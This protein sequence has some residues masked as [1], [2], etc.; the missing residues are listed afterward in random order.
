LPR[1]HRAALAVVT[2]AAGLACALHISSMSGHPLFGYP[3]VDAR[4][5]FEWASAVS[6]G[7][8][9]AFAPYFRAPLYPWILG[10]LFAL[11]GPS[12][13]AGAVLSALMVTASAALFYKIAAKWTSPGPALTVSLVWA[14]WAPQFFLSATLLM[15]P[16]YLLLLLGSFLAVDSG[17]TGAGMLLLGLS[18]ITRPGSVILLPAVFLRCGLVPG[19]RRL[20]L[21][22][23]PIAGVWAVNAIS[24]D[25]GT[26]ISSQGGVNFCLGNG[27]DADGVTAFAPVWVMQDPGAP[28]ED[29]VHA[30]SL[31]LAP[32]GLR[33]SAVSSWWTRRTLAEISA[34]F[35]RWLGLLGRKV[36]YFLS[37]VEVPGNYEMYYCRRYSFLL[38]S[39]LLPPPICV[40]AAIILLMLPGALAG[41]RPTRREAFLGIW[42]LLL[43]AGVVAFFVTSRLR[44]PC[45][46]FALILVA[47]RFARN[48][49]RSLLLAP[50]GLALA[51]GLILA[52]GGI[53]RMSGV[54]MPFYDALAHYSQGRVDEARALFL[55]SLGRAYERQDGL[56]LNRA[57]AMYD[58]GLLEAREGNLED[59]AS[60][61][62]AALEDNPG[63]G[64]AAHALELLG[65]P[66]GL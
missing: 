60:W 7:D 49:R 8:V 3:V 17:R 26:V 13:A 55:E 39:L 25:P 2:V 47:S 34:D 4:W 58:L 46:P 50:A 54:N 28:Y 51:A 21:F 14:L 66:G 52:T 45:V 38:R 18:A 33:E 16:L 31:A 29:N 24:G 20:P 43:A 56:S 6:R 5:H 59:A 63:F 36:M 42:A 1:G 44:L 10:A 27:T 57:E 22:L 48:L 15:E 41:A 62:R 65:S 23:L 35:P 61:F 30:A 40:P 53:V 9:F 11:T 37:P 32:E 19:L 12:V 64:P